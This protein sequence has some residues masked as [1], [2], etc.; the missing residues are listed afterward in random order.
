V[1][2]L[3]KSRRKRAKGARTK[4]H[5]PKP[6]TGARHEAISTGQP[7]AQSQA[8]LYSEEEVYE[9][10]KKAVDRGWALARS[11]QIARSPGPGRPKGKLQDETLTRITTASVLELLNFTQPM[12]APYLFPGQHDPEAGRK[13]VNKFTNQH[14]AAIAD[15]KKAMPR[16]LLEQIAKF[17]P[18]VKYLS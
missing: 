14:K 7:K 13:E 9:A 10:I 8:I 5:R 12:M 2:D 1:N 6:G 4:A 17:L 11:T 3:R 16:E 15:T 18:R